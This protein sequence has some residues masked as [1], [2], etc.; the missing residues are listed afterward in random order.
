VHVAVYHVQLRKKSTTDDLLAL[1]RV[2]GAD[3]IITAELL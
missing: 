1:F 2:S 3:R